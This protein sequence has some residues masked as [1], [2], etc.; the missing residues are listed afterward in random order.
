MAKYK[1]QIGDKINFN[2][3]HLRTGKSTL[4][5]G[6]IA[7]IASNGKFMTLRPHT[8]IINNAYGKPIECDITIESTDIIGLA[9]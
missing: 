2:H 6:T 7:W 8:V 4:E 1:P 5:S 3:T 9:K